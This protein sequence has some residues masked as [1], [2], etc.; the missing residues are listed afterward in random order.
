MLIIII[1]TKSNTSLDNY[2]NLNTAYFLE[3]IFYIDS[4]LSIALVLRYQ[5]ID[6]KS[7]GYYKLVNLKLVDQPKYDTTIYNRSQNTRDFFLFGVDLSYKNKNEYEIYSN[8]PQNYRSVTFSD[9]TITIP[10]FIIDPNITDESG[11]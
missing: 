10:T 9:I 1:H 6:I 5:Y 4:N 2:P 3:N 11:Y 7:D 8:I